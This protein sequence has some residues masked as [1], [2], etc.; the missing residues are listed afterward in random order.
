MDGAV[1]LSV[2]FEPKEQISPCISRCVFYFYF[3][4]SSAC[5]RKSAYGDE[6]PSF[7]SFGAGDSIF[8]PG[9]PSSFLASDMK[10][11]I[12]DL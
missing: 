12:F 1:K 5:L 9:V 4:D 10:S 2:T 7:N 3:L 11:A 8:Y 6:V